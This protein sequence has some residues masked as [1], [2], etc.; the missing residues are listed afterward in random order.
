MLIFVTANFEPGTNFL[1]ET[2]VGRVVASVGDPS[3]EMLLPFDRRDLQLLP[4][5]S[6]AVFGVDAVRGSPDG[7]FTEEGDGRVA[8]RRCPYGLI[9]PM[10]GAVSDLICE[11]GNEL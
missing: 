7:D 8:A 4:S 2:R 10:T 1:T 9:L 3:L 11:A 6:A 5:G